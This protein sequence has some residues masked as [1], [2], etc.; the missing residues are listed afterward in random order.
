MAGNYA[1]DNSHEFS[2]PL[3]TRT[4]SVFCYQLARVQ[5]GVAI[6]AVAAPR[7]MHCAR[8]GRLPDA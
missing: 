6:A 5:F 1:T 4:G 3:T 2:L 8:P 7:L